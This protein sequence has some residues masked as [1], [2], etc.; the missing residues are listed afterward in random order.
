MLWKNC[1]GVLYCS[2][3][4]S[5]YE[6]LEVY[7][8]PVS[9]DS[10][11]FYKKGKERESCTYRPRCPCFFVFVFLHL[12]KRKFSSA[13]ECLITRQVFFAPR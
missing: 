2:C 11:A 7:F 10:K 1:F 9:A 6:Y 12:A 8:S 13:A 4:I 5:L 3:G